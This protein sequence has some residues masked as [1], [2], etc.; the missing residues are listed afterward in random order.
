[1]AEI[2][3]LTEKSTQI[4]IRKDF[5]GRISEHAKFCSP[6]ISEKRAV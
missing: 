6:G 5:D 2:N 4:A 1:L 3:A